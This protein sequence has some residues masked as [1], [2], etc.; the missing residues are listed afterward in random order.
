MHF[1]E[2]RPTTRTERLTRK[3]TFLERQKPTACYI[4]AS[5]YA[6]SEEGFRDAN[7][8]SEWRSKSSENYQNDFRF[9]LINQKIDFQSFRRIS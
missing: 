1:L 4:I 6:P 5:F 3:F 7:E 8:S 9:L 2:R